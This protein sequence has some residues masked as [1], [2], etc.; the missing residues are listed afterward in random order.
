MAP[1]VFR[2]FITRDGSGGKISGKNITWG[3][4]ILGKSS[5]FWNLGEILPGSQNLRKLIWESLNGT[6][7]YIL[8][9][10]FVLTQ[11][12]RRPE[13]GPALF[14]YGSRFL[15][16]SAQLHMLFGGNCAQSVIFLANGLILYLQYLQGVQYLRQALF[17]DFPDFFLTNFSHFS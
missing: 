8:K 11:L 10:F 16:A 3:V 9:C 12:Q 6:L 14:Q 2:K 15:A 1:M 17:P 13:I 7:L 5:V 4:R